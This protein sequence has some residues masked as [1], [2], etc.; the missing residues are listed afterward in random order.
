[1]AQASPALVRETVAKW[2]DLFAD[3]RFPLPE[4]VL[5]STAVSESSAGG[6]PAG[7]VPTT[8]ASGPGPKAPDFTDEDITGPGVSPMDRKD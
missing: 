2:K 7:S 3:P 8:P 5:P 1:M 4:S 6:S